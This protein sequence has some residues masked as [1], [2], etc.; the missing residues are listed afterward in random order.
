MATG[1][2]KTRTASSLVDVLTRGGYVTN[3]LFLADRTALVRQARDDFKNYLPDLSLCNLL[4]NKDDRQ[5][6]IVFSTYPTMLNAIDS[7]R[8]Q[9]G[10][11][12][13]TPA[14]FDLIISDESHRS[15]FK[16]YRAIFDYFDAI[17]VGLTAT[18]KT[19]VDR[20]TYDFFEMEHGVPTYAYDYDTAVNQDHVLCPY[21]TIEVSTRFMDEGIIYE[22]LSP[23]DQERYREDFMEADG[24]VPLFIPSN[25]INSFV[26]NKKTVDQVLEDLMQKGIKINGGDKLAKTIIF[27]HNK[28]HAEFILERFNALYPQLKGS[29]A[30]RVICDDTY[31]Q[32][33]IDDFKQ[34]A[35]PT[36]YNPD[37]EKDPQIVVSV[38]MMDTGIDVP[39]IGNL[40]FFKSVRSK[41]KFWQMIGRG[42]RLCKGMECIDSVD[43]AYTDKRRFFIFDYCGNFEYFKQRKEGIEGRETTSLSEKIFSYR[44]R[45]CYDLQDAEYA[46]SSYQDLR[47]ETIAVCKEQ[48]R[49]LNN[50]R[51]AVQLQR[52]YVEK[53]RRP[54]VF[55]CLKESEK[56]ELIK[57]IAP[58]V[59]MEDKD[60][61]AKRF[62]DLMYGLMIASIEKS[63][64]F[65]IFKD[66]LLK[67]VDLLKKK[68][69]IP[70]VKQ[71]LPLLSVISEENFWKQPCI[72]QYEDVRIRLRPL[73]KFIERDQQA[74]V[75]TNLP[76]PV[77]GIKEGTQ[78]ENSYG[79][80]D[81]KKKVNRYIFEHK[82]SLVIHK[83]T[84]NIPLTA[85]DYTEL[86]RILTQE[87]GTLAD[88]KNFFQ[89]TP[90][91]LLIRSVAK[92][93]HQ[94]AMDAFSSFIN[95]YALNQQQIA[96]VDKVISHI[97]Q[98]GY[99]RDL[100]VL[101]KPPFDKPR[102]F[103]HLFA[104]LQQKALAET[105]KQIR[106][107]AMRPRDTGE[108]YG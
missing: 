73:I 49:S 90:F 74:V 46:A 6:R 60:E 30:K 96:F 89:D 44:I 53:F 33:I 20:N 34:P 86:E 27:A 75:Y 106:S 8:N 55:I 40:V 15:I 103:I 7:E 93:D 58:L 104:P 68:S 98:N 56:A 31:A 28:K 87:L 10:R 43:G 70:Q 81:Y 52:Q 101:T 35:P 95:D 108:I 12:L 64:N 3:V 1:T 77:I 13:F 39:Q 16:K 4:S 76:D 26:F 107:N 61:P 85:D 23:E 5:A 94:A 66:K 18:P 65:L 92:L 91:G 11:R 62:D 88:Y 38:D 42:T 21:K 45:L 71:E 2:G 9:E 25:K 47:R 36:H 17:T 22:K 24:S 102:S 48:I 41:T 105:I 37:D 59:F 69:T 50:Q 32:T 79:F 63:S 19:D 84:H 29:F 100:K 80:D 54:D 83:L 99:M 82:N 51:V 14:H 97:E 72:L 67:T 78:I 57:Y